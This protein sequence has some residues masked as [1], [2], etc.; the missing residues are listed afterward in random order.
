M[1][2]NAF[3]LCMCAALLW[4][5]SEKRG[6]DYDL[7]I[8]NAVIYDGRG[9]APFMG[10]VAVNGDT[11]AALGD[12]GDKRGREEIDAK[13]MAV[14]PGFINM[15]SWATESLLADGRAMSDLKQGVTLEVMGE[16]WSMGPL[17][18]AMKADM[19]KGQGD[20]KFDIPWTTLGEY[21]Q[22]LEQK[23]ISPNVASFVGAT[24]VR[25][26][27]LGYEDRAPTPEEL[28]RMQNLVRKA[29]QEGAMG[30]AS[31]LIYAPAFYADTD[32]LV[33][34]CQTASEHRGLYITHMRSEGN[35]LIESIDEVIDISLRAR[36]P[37][38]IYHLKAAGS[39]NWDKMNA[40]A[41]KLLDARERGIPISTNMYTYTAGATGLDASMPPWVQEGGF[42]AWAGRLKDPATRSRVKME[43]LKDADDWENLYAAAGSADKLLLVEFVTDSLKKYTG[44][45]LAEVA[46]LRGTSPE[47]TVMDL[48]VQDGSRVGVV[49]FLMSEANVR[50]QIGLPF[51]S[52]GSD[53]GAPAAEGDFLK[54]S[55]HPRAYGNFARLLGRYV[56]DEGLIPL[57]QAIRRLTGLPAFNLKLKKRGY[58][59]P[60]YFADIVIFDPATIADKATFEQPHQYAVGVEHVFING[61]HV[62]KNGEHTGATPGRFIRGPG[63]ASVETD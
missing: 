19:L 11:I 54:S 50:A 1:N 41:V 56:R 31:S 37:A 49:Y 59:Y 22:H 36:I 28:E 35:R 63:A 53:A 12:I 60:G 9:D 57:E 30:L 27:E 16:G 46:A 2:K 55:T 47:D 18:D 24:T 38:E 10:S 26:H 48:V 44:K 61:V 15:L 4:A 62:L 20:I 51:M 25:I 32:E 33:A 43:M 34:L 42:A 45:T 8:R 39:K 23:G 5:C 21:L 29:M 17:N 3:V 40:V 58:L 7:V 14:S 52:F 6:A 13:G